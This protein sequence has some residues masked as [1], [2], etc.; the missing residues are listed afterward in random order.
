MWT[1]S[2]I[3]LNG[4]QFTASADSANGYISTARSAYRGGVRLYSG[5]PGVA[6][7]YKLTVHAAIQYGTTVTFKVLGKSTNGTRAYEGLWNRASCSPAYV[8]CYDLKAIGPGYAWWAMSASS[9]LHLDGRTGYGVVAVPNT[10]GVRSFDV[11]KVRFVYRW[12]VLG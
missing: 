10:G 11:A 4:S 8:G 7:R 12:A 3:T 9:G 5:S 2:T 1:T 6:V